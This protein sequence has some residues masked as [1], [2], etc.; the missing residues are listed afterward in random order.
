MVVLI[1]HCD[2][3]LVFFYFFLLKFYFL[4]DYHRFMHGQYTKCISEI[5]KASA[6]GVK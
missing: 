5:Q 2:G 3:R 1:N 6:F 4:K